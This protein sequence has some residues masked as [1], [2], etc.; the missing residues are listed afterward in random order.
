MDNENYRILA[1]DDNPK[2][3]KV[4]AAI[5]APMGYE[6]EYAFS[7]MEAVH[8]LEVDTYDMI[9]LD[10]MMPEMD[11]YETCIRIKSMPRNELVPVIFLTARTDMASLNRAFT[12]GGVDYIM[13]PFSPDELLARI[14]THLELKSSRQKLLEVNTWLEKKVQERTEAL[15]SAHEELEKAYHSLQSLDKAKTEFLHMINHEI[16][17]PLNAIFGFTGFLQEE[18]E[19]PELKEHVDFIYR[20]SIRLEKFLAVVLQLTE[21]IAR[22]Q[23]L[24]K[25][26]TSIGRIIENSL[27]E[28]TV[29]MS[30][31]GIGANIDPE[32]LST[33]ING[34][35]KLMKSCILGIIENA[36]EYSPEGGR[37]RIGLLK[38]NGMKGCFISDSGPGFSEKAMQN[39]FTMFGMSEEHIDENV[40][41]DL[42]LAKMIMDAHNGKIEVLNLPEGGASVKLLFP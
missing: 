41:L 40:G 25:K 35:E 28:Y 3:L 8:M 34:N 13:K 15:R 29:Q 21:L 11:G 16:R 12:S 36:V 39:L 19:S 9:L 5:L 10:I 7:G 2:N 18:V 17:T 22:E 27:N 38:E 37:I 14:K 4:L 6:V 23:P 24:V 20:S 42:S 30:T 32:L 1:V 26:D 33:M 31:K